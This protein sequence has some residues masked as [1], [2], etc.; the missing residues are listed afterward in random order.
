MSEDMHTHPYDIP[1]NRKIEKRPENEVRITILQNSAC[2]TLLIGF[3]K[4]IHTE[5]PFSQL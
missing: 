3:S 5:N 2:Y 4:F 1:Y